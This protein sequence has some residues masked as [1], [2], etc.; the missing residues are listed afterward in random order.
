MQSLQHLPIAIHVDGETENIVIQQAGVDPLDP[1]F[2]VQIEITQAQ[3]EQIGNFLLGVVKPKPKTGQTGGDSHF[4]EFWDAYPAK[5]R[6]DR[7]HCLAK[8]KA[9][10][11]D[12]VSTA[13]IAHV[14]AMVKSEDW[15][16]GGGKYAPMSLT[17][18]NQSRWETPAEEE[19]QSWQ[20][21]LV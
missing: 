2:F 12:D 13:I 21:P 20:P 6:V 4:A 14:Q 1:D 18:I 3:A 15:T 5:R 16:K 11:L 19:Q 9:R 7:A 8:W 10:H 17:Y